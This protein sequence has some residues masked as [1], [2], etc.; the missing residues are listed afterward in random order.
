LND[1][2]VDSDQDDSEQLTYEAVKANLARFEA[3]I[4]ETAPIIQKYLF[5]ILSQD[6][7]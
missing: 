1:F 5:T 7:R 6:Q 3:G 4:L 2:F